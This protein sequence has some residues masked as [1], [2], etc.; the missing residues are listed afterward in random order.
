MTDEPITSN[1]DLTLASHIDQSKEGDKVLSPNHIDDV[2]AVLNWPRFED[3]NKA[4][5]LNETDNSYLCGGGTTFSQNLLY[6]FPHKDHGNIND[7]DDPTPI[8]QI[9][10]EAR[11]ELF[12][13]DSLEYQSDVQPKLNN[14]PIY[15]SIN[16]IFLGKSNDT[17][18]DHMESCSLSESVP[19]ISGLA[20]STEKMQVN[21]Y[22]INFSQ[23][24]FLNVWSSHGCLQLF[25][26]TGLI[27][28]T[29]F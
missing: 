27:R 11:E 9:V 17:L 28:D 6:D 21:C 10:L 13:Q 20:D 24:R 15:F 16:L 22:E 7:V 2:K 14:H 4:V 26:V 29:V 5:P 12:R 23:K 8:S 25:Q 1:I 18:S 19:N 3:L